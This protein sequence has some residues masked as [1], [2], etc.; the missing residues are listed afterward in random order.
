[1]SIPINGPVSNIKSGI[2]TVTVM[3]DGS[4][5]HAVLEAQIATWILD[6]GY[7]GQTILQTIVYTEISSIDASLGGNH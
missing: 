2:R 4:G 6:D 5:L 1:M 3:N 7:F